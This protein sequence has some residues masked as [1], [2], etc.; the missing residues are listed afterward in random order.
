MNGMHNLARVLRPHDFDHIIGQDIAVRMLKNTLYRGYFFPVYLFAGSRGC[1][2]TTSARIFGASINCE[3]LPTFQKQPKTTKIPCLSCFSCQAMRQG[4]HPDFIEVDAASHTGVDNVRSLIETSPLL[5][6][7]GRKKIYLIDEAH[8]LTKAACNAFLKI[9]EE[10]PATVL[11][12]L[13]TTD[14]Q[15][16]IET[17]RSRCFQLFFHPVAHE[18][19]VSYIMSVC[20]EEGIVAEHAGISFLVHESEGCVR[21]ALNLLEQVRFATEGTITKDAVM[22]VLGRMHDTHIMAIFELILVTKNIEELFSLLQMSCFEQQAAEYVWNRLLLYARALIW[23]HHGTVLSHASTT[24]SPALCQV[25]LDGVLYF[26]D[27]LY[28]Y[29]DIFM[30][31]TAQHAVLEM[32]LIKTCLFK[33]ADNDLKKNGAR[34]PVQEKIQKKDD[35]EN[36]GVLHPVQSTEPV[37]VEQSMPEI[38]EPPVAVPWQKF[39]SAVEQ[40]NDHLLL[41]IF[42]QARFIAHKAEQQIVEIAFGK[43]LV[44][45]KEWIADTKMTWQPLLNT[46]FSQTIELVPL[47][48]DEGR[49]VQ[50]VPVKKIENGIKKNNNGP[51][52]GEKRTFEQPKNKYVAKYGSNNYGS[53]TSFVRKTH[54]I[55]ISDKEL[56]KNTH[57]IL[58]YF[59]GIIVE[60][61]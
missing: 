56:W 20:Q 14:P 3:Q 12:M 58:H 22:Q 59:P 55:D 4:N 25:S 7:M 8:M 37:P 42:K 60:A 21:D 36:F 38:S 6:L 50:Q 30:K 16:I 53:S 17:V 35:V 15:K 52:A 44:F 48:I 29:H 43:E 28:L 39:V 24:L 19:L 49:G 13:A 41:S 57:A 31:T 61:K 2:K 26:L 54:V 47:F 27:Q 32:V 34:S 10:P 5:P 51:V 18:Q 23:Q 9:L 1:G 11:F 33:S 40:V 45:F 46:C